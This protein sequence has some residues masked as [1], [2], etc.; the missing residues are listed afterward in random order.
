MNRFVILF[1]YYIPKLEKFMKRFQGSCLVF[2]ITFL[3]SGLALAELQIVL[4]GPGTTE[5]AVK[6]FNKAVVTNDGTVDRNA[7]TE[8]S[9]VG[10]FVNEKYQARMSA[11]ED[12]KNHVKIKVNVDLRKPDL[13][14]RL[15]I[16]KSTEM[17]IITK[18][19]ESLKKAG[20]DDL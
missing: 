2:L 11:D 6:A 19:Y 12:K 14:Y 16:Q 9:S 8:Y 7:G 15:T 4:Q 20:Y 18:I 17:E 13:I 10:I 3:F 5:A 1:S